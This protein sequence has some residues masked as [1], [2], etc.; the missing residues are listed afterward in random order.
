MRLLKRGLTN[1]LVSDDVMPRYAIL[2]HTWGA[3]AEEVSCKDMIDG[4]GTS[5]PG[6]RFC[7]EQAV[8]DN[9]QY[10]NFGSI[11]AASINQAAL[12]SRR[13]PEQ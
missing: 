2:S 6:Y 7:G 1:N 9:L 4:A 10:F 8:S 11:R 12:S 3:D 5:K 13:T